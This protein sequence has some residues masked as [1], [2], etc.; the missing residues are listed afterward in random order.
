[1]RLRGTVLAVA[2]LAALPLSHAA[3][4]S[5]S[6]PKPKPTSVTAGGKTVCSKHGASKVCL[7]VREQRLHP[8]APV[9]LQVSVSATHMKHGL[10]VGFLFTR[11][12]NTTFLLPC[13]AN[14]SACAY[15][16]RKFKQFTSV[17]GGVIK[18]KK[19]VIY[20]SPMVKLPVKIV[21]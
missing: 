17:E 2:L 11:A 20:H 8:K 21:A 13:K 6:K 18:N 7:F 9:E 14:I 3:A 1:M 16:T 4:A 10:A 19:T 12:D 5:K 15:P